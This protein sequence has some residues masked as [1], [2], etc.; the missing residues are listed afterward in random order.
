M[1]T[2]FPNLVDW[3][4]GISQTV[5]PGVDENGDWEGLCTRWWAGEK[6]SIGW[7][8]MPAAPTSDRPRRRW[9]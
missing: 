5:P 8:F 2:R 1:A 3:H 4:D 7:A 9:A 6:A